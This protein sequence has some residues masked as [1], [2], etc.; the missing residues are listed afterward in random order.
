[1]LAQWTAHHARWRPDKVALRYEGAETTYAQLEDRVQRLA[2]ALVHSLDIQPGDRV[3]HLGLNHAD[4][5][6]LLFACARAGA[7][8]VPLNW[9]LTAAEHAFMID[10]CAP[11][12]LF[13][14][15]EYAEHAKDFPVAHRVA[16]ADIDALIEVDPARELPAVAPDAPV[17]ISYTSGTTGRPKG[18]VLSQAGLTWNAILSTAAHDITSADHALTFLPMFHVGGLHIHS[19]PVL[20][21]GGTVTVQHR[22]DPGA[23][24]AAIAEL[25][26]TMVLSVP[27]TSQ[28]KIAHPDFATTDVGGI[29]VFA[30]GSSTV[31]AAVMRPWLQRGVA[32][33][34]VYGLTESG[35]VAICL[36]VHDAARVG[37]CGKPVLH[38]QVRIVD[39]GGR[40]R[41]AGESGEIWV[42]SPSICVGYWNNPAATAEAITDGWLHTGDI[43]H[44]DADGFFFV[45][46]RKKDMVISGGENIYPAELEDIL[47]DCPAIQEAAVVG[48]PDPR[49]GEVPVAL[50]VAKPDHMLDAAAVMA[51][52]DG[53]LA[54][55]KLP[56]EVRFVD[57]LPRNVMGKVLKYELRARLASEA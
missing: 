1:M 40:D 7:I 34:Q 43:A 32:V 20:H 46:D 53:R 39:D 8:L 15:P 50:I 4:L 21:A 56:R 29:R 5:F 57:A 47:H 54:R 14:D 42:K 17:Q 27:A 6:T 36:P 44:V 3:A 35:P 24:L 48:K 38:A 37:S 25:R 10:D 41:P 13:L 16:M 31:P 33:T 9:R 18:A 26:P 23:A 2:V 22:F 12:V 45:D 30:T 52:F 11:K 19:T 49:W 55:Y 51:L 28:A